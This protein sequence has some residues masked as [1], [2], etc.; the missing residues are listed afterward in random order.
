MADESNAF[1]KFF[2]SPKFWV[3]CSIFTCIGVI[4][5]VILVPLSFSYVDYDELAFR[6]NTLSNFVDQD[7]VFHNGRYF[8]GLTSRPLTF[9]S[10]FQRFEYRG[11]DLEVFSAGGLAFMLDVDLYYRLNPSD[12][13]N[14]FTDFGTEY[15]SRIR[16]EAI[17][18]IKNTA[19]MFSVDDFVINRPQIVDRMFENL[20]RDLEQVHVQIEPEKLLLRRIIFPDNIRT[21]FL[22]TAVQD[23][24]NNRAI[25]QRDVDLFNIETQQFVES[26]RANVTIVNQ[27]ATSLAQAT[28]LNA[29]AQADEIRQEAIGTGLDIFFTTLNFQDP[30]SRE[31]IFELYSI[32]D[33]QNG[34]R[35]I[36]GDGLNVL[37]N[38]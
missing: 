35:V 22:R 28:V 15:D 6:R 3:T 25:L 30:T 32:I 9:P 24:E 13:S 29:R 2:K 19:T 4:L 11:T 12:L 18:S 5:V 34:A 26:I 17:A 21:I 14:I 31:R 27:T 7:E 38:S 20:N 10:I 8:W 37:I 1:A 16:D 23:L 33:S 36:V